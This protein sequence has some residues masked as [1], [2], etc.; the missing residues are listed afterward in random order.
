MNLIQFLR[1]LFGGRDIPDPKDRIKESQISVSKSKVVINQEGVMLSRIANTESMNPV[2][3]AGHN[4][5]FIKPVKEDLQVGDIISFKKA[6]VGNIM[7]RIIKISEDKDGWY[8]ITK[9]DNSSVSDGKVRF[10]DIKKV[11]VGIVY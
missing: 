5:L 2:I 3:D 9:G 11:L 6:G 7:H 1:G 8:C 10:K 4:A